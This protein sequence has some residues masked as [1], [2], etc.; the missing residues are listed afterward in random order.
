MYIAC[1]EFYEM[2]K[3]RSW[4]L[5]EVSLWGPYSKTLFSGL[6]RLPKL[7]FQRISITQ[8]INKHDQVIVFAIVNAC[9]WSKR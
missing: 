3:I 8:K 7:K 9:K 4:K 5:V 6:C 2:S 1:S